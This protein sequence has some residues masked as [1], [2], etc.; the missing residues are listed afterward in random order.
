MLFMQ[1][2][3][4]ANS[5]AEVLNCIDNIETTQPQHITQVLLRRLKEA[6]IENAG[7]YEH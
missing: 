1:V 3:S 5:I 4:G 2:L 6:R 7:E